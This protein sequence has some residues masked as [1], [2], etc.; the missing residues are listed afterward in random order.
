MKKRI[1][2]LCLAFVL[3]LST[4]PA[5]S[6][7]TGDDAILYYSED[8]ELAPRIAYPVEGGSIYFSKALGAVVDSDKSITSAAIPTEIDGIAVTRISAEAF[9]NCTQ[10]TS[11]TIPESITFIGDEAFYQCSALTDAKLPSGLRHLGL[12]AFYKAKCIEKTET[13]EYKDGWLLKAGYADDGQPPRDLRIDEG[14]IGIATSALYFSATGNGTYVRFV[15]P[16]TIRYFSA[17]ALTLGIGTV[18][19]PETYTD[20][21]QKD[22]CLYSKDGKSLVY[23]LPN[24]HQSYFV[25]PEGVETIEEG[26][27]YGA[28]KLRAVSLPD[29]LVT[30]GFQA[31]RLSGLQIIEFGKNVRTIGDFAFEYTP[32]VYVNCGQSLESVGIYA[33][34]DCQEL[35]MAVFPATLKEI[36]EGAF[37]QCEKLVNCCFEGDVPVIGD[38]TFRSGSFY[39]MYSITYVEGIQTDILPELVLWYRQGK[40]GWADLKQY[41]TSEW[42]EEEHAHDFHMQVIEPT[43]IENG[44]VIFTCSC[45]TALIVEELYSQGHQYDKWHGNCIHCGKKDGMDDVKDTDWFASSV[46]YALKNGLM[47]G[48]SEFVFAPN[49]PM[50]RAMLVT[51]L[52]RYE[53]SPKEG[54]NTFT[55][56]PA[57]Q[58]YTDAVAWAAENGIVGGV[59][60]GK[61]DPNGNITREQMAAI[62]YRYAQKKGF[63]TSAKGDLNGFPD[64]ASVS[65]WA[66]DAIAWTVAE[67]IINGNGG[68]LDPQ[69]NATRA[70]VATIL[71]RFIEGVAKK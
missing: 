66:T 15:L 23:Y 32:L 27:F 51:V 30:I 68:K 50:T 47:N 52:W 20:L 33:F 58:W 26:A 4:I 28:E 71:M 29:S 42:T 3:L 48:V 21:L 6:A 43:C 5:V 35:L 7:I 56:V 44:A 13:G 31:F 9:K 38:F 64:K 46:Y 49:S 65:A 59:G 37:Y 16:S 53:G 61:F 12:R 2:S 8:A 41:R 36:G 34:H 25:V 57:G 10:L 18:V 1:L 45:G 55:D 54:K 22:G 17:Q 70:Q 39:G 67:G 63:D 40:A 19:F 60:N 14:T 24:N 11:V 62:L 69:G